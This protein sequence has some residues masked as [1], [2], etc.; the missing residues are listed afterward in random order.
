MGTLQDAVAQQRD[1]LFEA[2]EFVVDER[3]EKRVILLQD[4]VRQA[5]DKDVQAHVLAQE[6][7]AKLWGA[8]HALES[9]MEI[10]DQR[11]DAVAANQCD[12]VRQQE[13]GEAAGRPVHGCRAVE[14]DAESCDLAAVTDV[15]ERLDQLER[16]ICV[17]LEEVS[18]AQQELCDKVKRLHRMV[19]V[20]R[21]VCVLRPT[22]KNWGSGWKC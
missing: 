19:N 17:N 22:R 16:G 4:A 15:V 9:R 13:S 7:E 8:V 2:V 3:T 18:S 10:A 5:L 21:A 12:L 6:S 1:D 14:L 20:T 11:V